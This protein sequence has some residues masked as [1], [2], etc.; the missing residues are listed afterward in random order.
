MKTAIG[1]VLTALV[2]VC[3]SAQ[4][5]TPDFSGTWVLDSAKSDFG[6]APAPSSIVSVIVHKEPTLTITTTQKGDQGE[7]VNERVITTDGK[8]NTNKLKTPMGEQDIRSTSSWKGATLTTAFTM[9]IQGTPLSFA[10]TWEL[11]ADGKVMTI[12]RVIKSDQGDFSQRMVFN[13]Q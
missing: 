6:P 2:A 7:F 3:L 9:D 10:D 1:T 8:E 11:S 5:A 13:K 4:G 12:S